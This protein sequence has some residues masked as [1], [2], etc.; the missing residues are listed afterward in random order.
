MLVE[1][2]NSYLKDKIKV[3]KVKKG[4]RF[5]K[6]IRVNDVDYDYKKNKLEI[7]HTLYEDLY[8]TFGINTQ[9]L[10]NYNGININI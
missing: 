10:K 4:I 8:E 9:D 2:I 1:L 3:T 6:V 5:V 7:T